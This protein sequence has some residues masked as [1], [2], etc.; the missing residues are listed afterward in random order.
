MDSQRLFLFMF[1][2]S[3]EAI[4]YFHVNVLLFSSFVDVYDEIAC[5]AK[6][7][8][9]PFLSFLF[10]SSQ[11]SVGFRELLFEDFHSIS[12]NA[13]T[14]DESSQASEVLGELGEGLRVSVVL[15]LEAVRK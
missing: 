15:Q 2:I 6:A 7:G 3:Y 12:Q 9:A 13:V 5:S 1:H 4:V 11:Y 10:L 8:Q 14:C